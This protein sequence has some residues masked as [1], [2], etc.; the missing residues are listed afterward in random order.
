MDK[1]RL[2]VDVNERSNGSKQTCYVGL[3]RVRTREGIYLMRPFPKEAFQGA[4]PLGPRTLLKK[5][6]GEVMDW[7]SVRAEMEGVRAEQGREK[8]RR[9]VQSSLLTCSKCD[10][11]LEWSEFSESQRQKGEERAC[12]RCVDD[13]SE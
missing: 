5:L 4:A 8:R 13:V 1:D 6:R 10:V 11:L 12:I 9:I 2:A 7:M 3:S